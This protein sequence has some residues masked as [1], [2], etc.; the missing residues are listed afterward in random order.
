[1][2]HEITAFYI[3]HNQPNLDKLCPVSSGFCFDEKM[4]ETVKGD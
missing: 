3:F 1:M 2:K 4:E